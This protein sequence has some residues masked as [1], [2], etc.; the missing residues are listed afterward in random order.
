LVFV[1][2]AIQ[3]HIETLTSDRGLTRFVELLEAS[4]LDSRTR[5]MAKRSAQLRLGTTLPTGEIGDRYR[6]PDWLGGRAVGARLAG[7]GRKD[8][9]RSCGIGQRLESI[10]R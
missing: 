7:R 1:H 8:N 10:L 4:G 9:C 3:Q 6:E 5:Y 2:R